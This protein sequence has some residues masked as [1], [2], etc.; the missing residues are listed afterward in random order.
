[1]QVAEKKSAKLAETGLEGSLKERPSRLILDHLNREKFSGSVIL[2]HLEKRKR[3]WFHEGEIFRIQSNL[4]PELMGHLMVE[5]GWIN[6]QDLRSILERQR[7]DDRNKNIGDWVREKLGIE[8]HEIQALFELQRMIM[9]IQAMTWEEG[10]YSIHAHGVR[11][12]DSVSVS[13]RDLIHSL[14]GIVDLD[15]QKLGA[16]FKVI[17]PWQPHAGKI[18][19]NETPLWAV[20]AGT[21]RTRANGILS[22]RKHN[23]LY[24]IIFKFGIPLTYYEGTFGQPRQVVVVRQASDEHERFFLDQIFRLFSFSTG[25]AS[26]RAI[27]QPVQEDL[28]QTSGREG[29]LV[30]RSVKAG[31]WGVEAKGLSVGHSLRNVQKIISWIGG[32]GG[33]LSSKTHR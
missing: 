21:R 19:L 24:E 23:R 27:G 7:E 6:E 18:N 2:T 26:F 14:Q 28:S 13:Y 29:T 10:Q 30:T 20:F 5:K 22:V 25:S 4:A 33:S 3:L 12:P 11:R 8:K 16:L 9:L 17:R 31:D 32:L 1:M 15:T